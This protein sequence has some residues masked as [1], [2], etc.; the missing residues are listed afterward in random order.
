ME[1]RRADRD[2]RPAQSSRRK[3][4]G[5]RLRGSITQQ[6]GLHAFL[7]PWSSHRHAAPLLALIDYTSTQDSAVRGGRWARP[8]RRRPPRRVH[9]DCARHHRLPPQQRESRGPR[10]ASHEDRG[11]P[12]LR[13]SVAE[14]YRCGTPCG[15]TAAGRGRLAAAQARWRSR[16]WMLYPIQPTERACEPVEKSSGRLPLHFRRKPTT[17]AS[18]QPTKLDHRCRPRW[19]GSGGLGKSQ[20]GRKE[21]CMARISG[22]RDYAARRSSD[23]GRYDVV[24]RSQ[25][26]GRM[27]PRIA[28]SKQKAVGSHELR[29]TARPL[30]TRRSAASY[31]ADR[32]HCAD[33][34]CREQRIVALL[35]PRASLSARSCPVGPL[36]LR[37][38]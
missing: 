3:S 11:G 9:C 24:A 26:R 17:A 13:G 4:P 15:R 14:W 36:W 25:S 8:R 31:R 5:R 21:Q 38:R 1:G 28:R 16:D 7:H 33:H 35:A 30:S 10:T 18:D 27:R 37:S 19:D 12:W 6:P 2:L 20:S 23:H 29:C 34:A 22:F 32:W